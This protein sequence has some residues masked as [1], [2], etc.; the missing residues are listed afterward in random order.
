MEFSDSKNIFL[1][2]GE[3]IMDEIMHGKLIPGERIPS[4]RELAEDMVVNRNTVNKTF[5]YLNDL[6]ILE[7]KRGMGYFV[8]NEAI[9][10]VKNLRKQVFL[11][12]QLPKLL[13]MVDQ[14]G[15]TEKDFTQLFQQLKAN[16]NENE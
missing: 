2:I 6:G 3:W 13:Q 12:E 15:L 10:I 4:V 5:T 11:N 8:S 9:Q 7:N 16:S 14:L 1:Q